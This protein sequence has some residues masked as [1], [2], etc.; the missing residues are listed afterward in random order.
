MKLLLFV[1]FFALTA[2]LPASETKWKADITHSKALFTVSHMVI[3]EVTGRFTDF[4]VSLVQNNSDFS[5]SKVSVTFKPASVNTDDESRDKHLRSEDFFYTEKYPEA[6]FVSTAFDKTGDNI[7][8]ITGDLTLRGITKSVT[9]NAKYN[10]SMK[11]PWGNEKAGFKVTGTIKRTDFGLKW[12]KAVEAGG[13]LVGENVDL[14]FQIEL[15][16]EKPEDVKK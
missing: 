4:D 15:A 8:T 12:N 7:F 1:L 16:Q 13:L 3:S 14:T 9:L 5:G 2:L 11:D 10:G 6:T